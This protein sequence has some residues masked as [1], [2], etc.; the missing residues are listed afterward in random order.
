MHSFKSAKIYIIKFYNKKDKHI[1]IGSTIC[2]L[3][4]RF[5]NH[6]NSKTTISTYITKKYKNNWNCC[7]IE[8]YLDF[9]CSNRKTLIKKEYQII[10]KFAKEKK[11]KVL[12]IK[13]N[14]YR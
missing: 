1:Y 14:K 11:F 10:N 4:S 5:S 7:Y 12:N 3:K 2:N 9:P 8:K 13:G 6:K